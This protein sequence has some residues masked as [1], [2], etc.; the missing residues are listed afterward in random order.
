MLKRNTFR[1]K[2]PY[3][4]ILDEMLNN[5]IGRI[6]LREKKQYPTGY[7]KWM[8]MLRVSKE[9]KSFEVK[10]IRSNEFM[11]LPTKKTVK[12]KKKSCGGKYAYY[13]IQ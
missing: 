9:S 3:H 8:Y 5:G 1:V 7:N 6:N 12:N 10:N 2:K 11:L 13:D 4:K